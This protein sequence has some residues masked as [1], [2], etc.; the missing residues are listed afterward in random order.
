MGEAGH[1]VSHLSRFSPTYKLRAHR[2]TEV[3][4]T[5]CALTDSLKAHRLTESST[6]LLKALRVT[7]RSHLTEG[8]QTHSGATELQES[9]DSEDQ[10]IHWM[11]NDSLNIHRLVECLHLLRA[12]RLIEGSTDRYVEDP[13]AD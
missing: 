6:D 4:W 1:L 3:P 13:H 5:N 8:P 7:K 10:L 11:P 9:T 2:L 12:L